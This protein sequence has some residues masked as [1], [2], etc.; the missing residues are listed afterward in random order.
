MM[1]NQTSMIVITGGPCA[2]KTSIQAVLAERCLDIG[3]QTF[4]VPEAATLLISGGIQPSFRGKNFQKDVLELSL[5]NEEFWKNRVTNSPAKK[6]VI[7]CDRGLMDGQAYTKPSLFREFLADFELDEVQARDA[8]YEGVIHLRTAALGAEE[9]YTLDNNPA[10]SEGIK[11]A[12]DL[13]ERTLQAWVGH[14]HLAVVPNEPGKDFE[15]KKSRAFQEVCRIL[16]EPVP[17]EIER[18]FLIEEPDFS[19]FPIPVVA[20]DILQYYLKDGSRVRVRSQAGSSVY[21]LTKKQEIRPGVRNEIERKISAQEFANFLLDLDPNSVP[22]KKKRFCFVWKEQYFELDLISEPRILS[23]L[24]IELTEEQ[25]EIQLPDFIKPIR[26]VT[27]ERS[28]SNRE[29]ARAAASR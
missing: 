19:K 16:G 2:G 11:E 25:Q 6:K 17:L 5:I 10:R 4:F 24:E 14:P 7:F 20:I 22:I 3:Y 8:R 13:D 21:F 26:D 29:I 28:F 1:K 12:R 23:L 9:F 27:D 18:K 15:H